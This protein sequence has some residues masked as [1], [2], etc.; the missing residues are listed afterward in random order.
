MPA[1]GDAAPAAA[2][3]LIELDR[4]TVLRGEVRALHELSLRIGLGQHTAILGANGSG[5]STFVKLI[6][7]ELYP[8]A[9]EGETP[10]R[11]LGQGLWDVARLRSQL[12]IVSG[13][14][15]L[16]LRQ[17]AGLDAESAVLTGFFASLALEQVADAGMRERARAALAQVD[18][19]ALRGRRYAELSTGEARRVLV[20]RAL[21]HRPRAL[22]LDE[23][24]AG[25]DPVARRRL[26]R[27]LGGLARQGITLLLVTH[28]IEEIVPEIGRV[29]LL[30]AGRVLADG[31]PE[32][33][34]TA[35]LLGAAYGGRVDVRRE[36]GRYAL[37]AI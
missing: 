27:T 24:T 37:A 26:L 31:A 25:L 36:G 19:L 3:P 29:V 8:L 33:V 1:P 34:L 4:A 13:D 20:A 14:L 16:D 12:G 11:V 23:P 15:G 22:L 35:E 10:V 7:R 21:V 2:A 6:T 9:R 28:H 30:R 32:A 5:K 17:M 18:A